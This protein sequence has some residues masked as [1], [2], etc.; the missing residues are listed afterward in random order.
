[1]HLFPLCLSQAKSHSL[2]FM[3]PWRGKV[4]EGTMLVCSMTR[5]YFKW[6]FLLI[7]RPISTNVSNGRAIDWFVFLMKSLMNQNLLRFNPG[8][9]VDQEFR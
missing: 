6:L 1:M 9:D 2:Q 5:L 4:S 7:S 8:H 3:L